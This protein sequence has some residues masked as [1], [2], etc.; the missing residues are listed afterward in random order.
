[1]H[2]HEAANAVIFGIDPLWMSTAILVITYVILLSE[3]VHRTVIALFG[4]GVAIV[5]DVLNQT[6]AIAGIDFNTIALLTG[7]MIIVGITKTTGV[8]E[9]VAIWSAARRP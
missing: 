9:F 2:G 5:T 3:K 1:M 8:F 4:A 7:M 6:Q